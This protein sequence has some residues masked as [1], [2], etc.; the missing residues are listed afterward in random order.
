MEGSIKKKE[1]GDREGSTK[2]EREGR[3][4][5]REGREEGEGEKEER[6]GGRE[7]KEEGEGE[8]ARRSR[9]REICAWV[10]MYMYI[11]S[12]WCQRLQSWCWVG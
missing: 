2:E 4:G 10:Y 12:V 7:G 1:K 3:E 9:V 6:E 11:P 8:K 5:G